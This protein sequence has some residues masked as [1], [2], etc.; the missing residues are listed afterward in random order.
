MRIRECWHAI[1]ELKQVSKRLVAI[2]NHGLGWEVPR[3]YPWRQCRFCGTASDRDCSGVVSLACGSRTCHGYG[4][5]C[6]V[7]HHGI[8]PGWSGSDQECGYKRCHERAVAKV[9]RVG[10]ACAAHVRQRYVTP[11]LDVGWRR[12]VDVHEADY[13]ACPAIALDILRGPA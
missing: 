4:L 10:A 9:P 13:L 5:H 12:W 2:H 11:H 6:P 7:C 8:R 1:E 3:L